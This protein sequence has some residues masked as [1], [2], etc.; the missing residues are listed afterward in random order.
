MLKKH[1][2]RTKPKRIAMVVF[3]YYP[4]DERVRREA[5]ALVSEGMEVDVIC[6]RGEKEQIEDDFNKVHI[7]R[8]PI[9]RIRSGIFRY[10][11]Q[12]LVFILLAFLK[13]SILHIRENYHIIHVHNMPD[14]LVFSALLPW[15]TGAKVVLDLHDPMPEMYMT[16]YSI[17]PSHPLIRALCCFEHLS[18]RFSNLVLTPNKAFRDLFISRGCPDWKIHIVMNSPQEYIFRRGEVASDQKII[19]GRDGFVLM[20]HG[21]I[22]QR[23]G[24]DIAV[25]ALARLRNEIPNVIFHAYGPGEFVPQFLEQVDRLN[26]NDI[27]KYHGLVS[28]EEIASAIESINLGIIPNKMTPFTNLNLPTRIFEYL[29]MNKPVVAPRT[30]GIMDYFDEDSIYFFEAGKVDS[31]TKTILDVYRNPSRRQSVLA[32]GVR[33]YNE[34]RWQSEKKHFVELVTKLLHYG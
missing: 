14:I 19:I 15:L 2:K 11:W 5:E 10:L 26:L 16:K 1:C 6:L 28:L 13:L 3:A 9:K 30:K 20:F 25:E 12:Y 24:L 7:Y 33:I 8:L 34:H 21:S 32:K 27:I 23:H 22:V 4:M 29:A 31:L 18:I 17:I